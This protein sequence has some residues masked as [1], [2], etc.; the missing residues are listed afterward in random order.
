MPRAVAFCVVAMSEPVIICPLEIERRAAERAVGGRAR[1]VRC[2]PGAEAVRAAVEALKE[3][4]PSLVVLFGVAGGIRYTPLAPRI[5]GVMSMATGEQW[6][7]NYSVG[8]NTETGVMVLGVDEVVYSPVRKRFLRRKFRR[9][10]L[11][12][13]ESHAFAQAVSALGWRWT[14]VRGISDQPH[15]ALPKQCATWVNDDGTPRVKQVMKD[16]A[17]RP[18]LLGDVLSL[19][20]RTNEGL[21]AAAERLARMLILEEVAAEV[22]VV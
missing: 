2:G 18:L 21:E 7:V 14:I 15:H 13:C 17:K 12:D 16:L 6:R 20:S 10:S 1:V 22:A 5:A 11:V 9:I 19:R 3:E 4:S 8:N